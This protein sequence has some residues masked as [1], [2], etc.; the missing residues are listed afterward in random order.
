MAEV[1][2]DLPRDQ[3]KTVFLLECAEPEMGMERV[4]LRLI[5]A[6]S[7]RESFGVTVLGGPAPQVSGV[8]CR[9]LGAQPR[10][11]RRVVRVWRT[12][13]FAATCRADRVIVVGAWVAAPWL[14]VA[15]RRRGTIVWEHSLLREKWVLTRKLMLLNLWAALVY[16]RAAS[17]VT[18]SRPLMRDVSRFVPEAKVRLIP[19]LIG[20]DPDTAPDPDM[21][22]VKAPRDHPVG[23]LIMVGNLSRLKNQQL[24]INALPR[25]PASWTVQLVGDGPARRELEAIVADLGLG[26]R[27]DFLG[28]RTHEDTLE[29]IRE[30]DVLVHPSLSETF[31]L[32]YFEA[33][34]VGTPVVAFRNRVSDWLIPTYVPGLTIVGSEE[35]LATALEQTVLGTDVDDVTAAARAATNRQRDFAAEVILSEWANLLSNAPEERHVS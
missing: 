21:T 10:H 18:V 24:L 20:Q 25:L 1:G 8:E 16:W 22:A 31:G 23:R 11:F 28:Y 27:I 12:L 15:S 13:R 5:R 19:N 32:V 26:A 17:V 7:T 33:A 30:A 14:T 29:L 6:L 4:A 2:T 3:R 35:Q 34:Q 9:S